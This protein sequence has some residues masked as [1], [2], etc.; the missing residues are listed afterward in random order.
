MTAVAAN[1][2][3]V[4]V[5]PDADFA[6]KQQQQHHHHPDGGGPRGGQTLSGNSAASGSTHAAHGQS[7]AADGQSAPR[8]RSAT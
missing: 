5:G 4:V 3:Q 2:D 1:F 7:L 8:P 6:P